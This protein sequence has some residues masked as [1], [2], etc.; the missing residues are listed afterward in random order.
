M[1]SQYAT[2][3]QIRISFFLSEPRGACYVF[4][5][6]EAPATKSMELAP[7]LLYEAKVICIHRNGFGP[8]GEGHIRLSFSGAENEINKAFDRIKE[9]ARINL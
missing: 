6:I 9:W 2:L 8:S 3:G 1:I 4:P 7:R 5:R